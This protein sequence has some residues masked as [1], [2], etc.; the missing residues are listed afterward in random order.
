MDYFPSFNQEDLIDGWKRKVESNIKDLEKMFQ[1]DDE[2]KEEISLG[3][4]EYM[5]QE[6]NTLENVIIMDDRNV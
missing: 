1:F 6:G 4:S 2:S 3:V 5:N